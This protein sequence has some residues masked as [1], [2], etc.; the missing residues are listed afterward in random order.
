MHSMPLADRASDAGYRH[1]VDVCWTGRPT[2]LS[3]APEKDGSNLQRGA[4]LVLEDI[5]ANAAQLVDIW[6]V[7]LCEEADLHSL[8]SL[9]TLQTRGIAARAEAL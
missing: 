1:V 4:P 8:R 2:P 3:Y 7:D 6:V 5:Q 9:S